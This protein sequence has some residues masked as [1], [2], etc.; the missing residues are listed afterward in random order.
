MQEKGKM[1]KATA[2]LMETGS[3]DGTINRYDPQVFKSQQL[4]TVAQ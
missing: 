3:A 4:F 2:I 1:V